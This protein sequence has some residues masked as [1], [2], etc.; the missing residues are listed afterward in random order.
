VTGAPARSGEVFDPA[1]GRVTKRV[2]FASTAD[3]RRTE[4]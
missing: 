3:C 1:A 4:G 2:A